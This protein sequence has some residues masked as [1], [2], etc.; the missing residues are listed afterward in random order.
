MKIAITA[1]IHLTTKKEHP[2]RW[3][4][5]ENILDDISEKNINKII[6]C[7]DLFNENYRNYSEFDKLTSKYNNIDF[8]IIPGNHDPNISEKTITGRNVTIYTEP[9]IVS[10]NDSDYSFFFLPYK[11]KITMGQQF[12]SYQDDLKPREWAL[13][14]HGD[15]ADSIRTPNP[16]EPGVYMP[17]SR[18][19]ITDYKPVLTILGHIHKPLDDT[20]YNVHYVG[21]PCGLDI[22]ETGRRRYLI[23]DTKSLDLEHV[24][25]DS[26]VIYFDET[27]N[28]WPM[29][30]EEDYLKNQIELIKEKWNL[31]PKEKEK[32]KIRIKVKGYSSNIRKLKEICDDVFIDFSFWYDKGVDISEVSS[33]E[34]YDL[35]KIS[36]RVRERINEIDLEKKDG[37]PT[38]NDII[39]KALQA[40][41][42]VE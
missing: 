42:R 41:Y 40:I 28:I 13:I 33:S 6:I 19:D 35:L 10:F 21:S 11:P 27:I 14:T 15:W 37:E 7:G 29:E 26:E 36:E 39:F 17:L 31:T 1:D 22:T 38:K 20:G 18:K 30:N 32:A 23:L 2:E 25:V 24:N 4:T 34:N 9:E 5:F 12:V 3:K 8:F 16:I